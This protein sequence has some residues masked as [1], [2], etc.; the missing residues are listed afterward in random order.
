MAADQ[1]AQVRALSERLTEMQ[2][3]LG[4][5]RA[6]MAE[7]RSRAIRSAATALP[8]LPAGVAVD[9]PVGWAPPMPDTSY[10]AFPSVAGG[11]VLIAGKL[12]CTVKLASRTV[13]GCTVTVTNT[14]TAGIA[15]ASGVLWVLAVNPST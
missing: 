4:A 8:A 13:D 2:R 3:R 9:V 7:I 14:N 6:Q 5:A 10:Q 15:D 11:P 1:A 12:Q